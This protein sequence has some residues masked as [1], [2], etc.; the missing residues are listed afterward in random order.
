MKTGGKYLLVAFVALVLGIVLGAT[1]PVWFTPPWVR[2]TPFVYTLLSLVWLPLCL[3]GLWQLLQNKRSL[4]FLLA[5][6][7]LVGQCCLSLTLAPA[8]LGYL[9]IY[10][11][12]H[13]VL[14]G[15]FRCEETTPQELRCELCIISSDDPPETL[16]TY[17]FRK[18]GDLPLMRLIQVDVE[19][20]DEWS[21]VPCQKP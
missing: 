1:Q 10:G 8:E 2:Y 4:F 20:R 15:Y 13:P 7:I 19:Y 14:G 17:G 16:R 21:I 3:Y 18:F 5:V 6:L 11:G 12:K 9:G